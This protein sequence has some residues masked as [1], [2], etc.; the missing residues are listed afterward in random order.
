M[1]RI[2]SILILFAFQCVRG[3]STLRYCRGE[4]HDLTQFCLTLDISSNSTT[5]SNDFH[6]RLEARFKERKGWLG[7]GS[8]FQMDQSLMF[9]MYPGVDEGN[10]ATLRRSLTYVLTFRQISF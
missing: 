6:F 8:G 5:Q 9:V 2:I 3:V 10:L 4:A 1:S 7:I